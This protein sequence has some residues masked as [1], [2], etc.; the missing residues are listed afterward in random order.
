MKFKNYMEDI[1]VS[2]YEDFK[3][4]YPEF[5]FC[6]RCRKDMIAISLTRLKGKYAV[7]AE[8]EVLLK[9]SR[10]D[11]QMKADALLALYEAAQIVTGNPRH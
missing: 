5:C 10:E 1:V 8:G 9:L 3:A 4:K 7:T 2:V 11:R 6:D